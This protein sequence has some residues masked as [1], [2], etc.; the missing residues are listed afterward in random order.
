M[1]LSLSVGETIF[2]TAEHEDGWWEGTS[3][4]HKGF[5]PKSHV[6]RRESGSA[7]K[8]P[9][10]PSHLASEAAA[11]AAATAAA[12]ATAVSPADAAESLEHLE[13]DASVATGEQFSLE[14]LELFDELMDRGYAIDVK[15]RGGGAAVGADMRVTLACKAMTWDGAAT[16]VHSF[17]E[18]TLKFTASQGAALPSGLVASVG[19]LTV[20]SRALIT[21]APHMAYGDAGHPPHVKPNS[22]IVYDVNVLSADA[23]T[24]ADEPIEGPPALLK[25]AV[26]IQ[27]KHKAEGRRGS[28]RVASVVFDAS[29]VDDELIA[30]A[31]AS[32]LSIAPSK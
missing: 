22:H 10:R 7:P 21:C 11:S 8:L 23:A 1:E 28:L 24:A 30:K 29:P 32:G 14:S 9:P 3:G 18:G 15:E 12:A 6:A 25:S 27:P 13:Y 19:Q 26:T 4:T 20:G 17:A 31:I 2:V 5:F 16:V